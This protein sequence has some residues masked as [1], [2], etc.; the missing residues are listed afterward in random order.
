MRQSVST[1]YR[2][3]CGR[4][5]FKGLL[6]QG[7][8]EVKCHRCS[9][10]TSFSYAEP[11]LTI[12]IDCDE[13]EFVRSVSGSLFLYPQYQRDYLLGKR[14]DE[15]VPLLREQPQSSPTL[16]RYDLKDSALQL[17]DGPAL[18]CQSSWIIPRFEGG[19]Y[20]GRCVFGVVDIHNL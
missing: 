16:A 7:V 4:L 6:V 14:V 12:L 2:C 15:V 9:E 10:H 18:P 8:V 11:L 5:L 20:Q 17:R 13:R 3:A 19:I 1:E